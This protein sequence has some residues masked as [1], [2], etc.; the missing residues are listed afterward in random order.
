MGKEGETNINT[1]LNQRATCLS[2]ISEL[3]TTRSQMKYFRSIGFVPTM[4][5]LHEGH[6]SLIKRAKEENDIVFVSIFVNPTQFGPNDDFD[7]Y[8]RKIDEDVTLISDVGCDYVF[9]PSSGD[10][11]TSNHRVDVVPKGF[12]EL[13]EG[14]A[15]PGHFRG[16][17]TVVSKLFNLVQPTRAYFGQKDAMQCVVIKRLIEDLNFNIQLVV[18]PT[19]R[20]DDGLAMSSRNNYLKG[21]EERQAATV[22]YRALMAMKKA[23]LSHLSV[24]SSSDQVQE[25]SRMRQDGQ[26]GEG[27]EEEEKKE[28]KLPVKQTKKTIKPIG[29]QFL[30]DIGLQVLQNE[31][32]V[33]DIEYISFGSKE[34]ME[35]LEF[36]SEEGAIVSTAI[37][38]GSVR[39]IDNM[40]M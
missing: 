3:R 18:C 13:S 25:E 6:L 30:R 9:L 8:P 23:F 33:S 7:Q 12:E 32:L 26:E 19:V 27:E 1:N 28:G 15:R 17:A 35:E 39:L 10:M 14:K 4:G 34:T 38:L 31:P 21:E 24:E 40:F 2:S 5:A 36:I 11:Y 22:V 37:K 16:V 29:S 20:E